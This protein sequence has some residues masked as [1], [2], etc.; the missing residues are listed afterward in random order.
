M[1]FEARASLG[2]ATSA[3]IARSLSC[4]GSDCIDN[5]EAS[6]P[7]VGVVFY[8]LVGGGAGAVIGGG[9]GA[10]LDQRARERHAEGARVSQPE[11]GIP[12]A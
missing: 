8:G 10:V 12:P 5:G 1:R 2:F 3:L 6:Y 4:P 7:I 9:I 11:R